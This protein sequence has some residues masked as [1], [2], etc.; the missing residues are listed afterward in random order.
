[1]ANVAGGLEVEKFGCV[2]VTK[3]EMIADLRMALGAADAKVRDQGELASELRLRQSRGEVIVFTNGCYDLLHVGHIRFLEQCRMHGNVLVVGLNSDSSV[4]AQNKGT[5]RPI[6]PQE[7]RAEVL[8]AL[9]CVD[10]VTIFDEPTPKEIVAKLSPNVL[11]KGED[12][13]NKGVVGREHVE[14]HG[15]KVVLLPLIEGVSTT[16]IVERIRSGNKHD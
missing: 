3:G 12:W 8:A 5:N 14:A 16:G 10:F 9:Q 7:Q 6:V 2:P 4:R 11:I 1:L 13:A 15:G